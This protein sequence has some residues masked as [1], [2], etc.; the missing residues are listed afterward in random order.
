M[1]FGFL[2]S[3]LFLG[4]SLGANDASN[5]FGTAVG[6]RMIKFRTA[7]IYCSI[8][9]ILGA[10]VSG[11]GASHTLG[12]LGA[13]NAIAGAFIVAFSAAMSVYLMTL[14]KFPVSTSQAIVGAII[15]WNVF[16]GSVTDVAS[17]TKI[18]STW[19]FCPLLAAG[20]SIILYLLSAFMIRFC[21]IHMFKLDQITRYSL[22]LAGI[23]G[24][25]SLGANN[26]ANV[27]GVFVPVAPFDSITLGGF[28]FSAAQ[29]LFLVGGIAIAVGVFTY[30]K[31]VMMTVGT[32]IFELTP[33]AAAVVVWS[34]SIVLFLFSSQTL[35][36][37]LITHHLPSFP[38][39]PVSSSQAIVGAVI[40]IGL[41]KG[42]KGIRW[43]TVG[44]I[45]G[46][47]ITTPIISALISLVALFFL[48]NVFMQKTFEPVNYIVTKDA[49]AYIEQQ[50]GNTQGIDQLLWQEFVNGVDFKNGVEAA[51]P[52]L[53]KNELDLFFQAARVTEL[54][55][56]A[57]SI[58][59]LTNDTFSDQQK[60]I[61]EEFDGREFLYKWQFIEA[62]SSAL[63]K[64]IPQLTMVEAEQQADRIFDK[65]VLTR[66]R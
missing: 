39:V 31:R 53:N 8:F 64:A 28:T 44:G 59:D 63:I 11:A 38:L 6:S 1:F 30:S 40:G 48:Q 9:V 3:G 12:K 61:I 21:K 23:F 66:K 7:A 55:I 18:V 35:E 4:W 51:A 26:I 62:F 42:G 17:L 65:L 5:V 58:E 50:K 22:L 54:E 56:N 47:W 15:G 29:Q 13:V 25:Y 32:G 33:V 20:F 41:L 45:T 24:S 16:S 34:H 46:G 37:W 60:R 52:G 14:A 27:M 19:V 36:A 43:K 2:S 57:E 10:V 49:A